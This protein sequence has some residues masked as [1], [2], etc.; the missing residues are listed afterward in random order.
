MMHGVVIREARRTDVS[1]LVRAWRDAGRF[2]VETDAT[3]FQVPV[4]EGL[5]ES[6]AASLE[7]M[8]DDEVVLVAERDGEVLAFVSARVLE[9]ADDAQWQIQRELAVRR[10]HIDAV[11]VSEPYRR[12]R[13]GSALV[14]AIEESAR[15]RG[16]AVAAV[17]GNWENGVAVGFYEAG[18]GY[19]RRGLTLHKALV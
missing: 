6:F 4:E 2:A 7:A 1:G 14:R 11:A 16:C 9:P 3:A 17:D 15:R 19:R 12:Q 18:L 13:V 10:L 8:D 5:A